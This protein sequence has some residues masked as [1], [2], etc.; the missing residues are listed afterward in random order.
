MAQKVWTWPQPQRH[1]DHSSVR[2]QNQYDFITELKIPIQ[3]KWLVQWKNVVST[4][5]W[6][7]KNADLRQKKFLDFAS[8][9]GQNGQNMNFTSGPKTNIAPNFFQNIFALAYR[10]SYGWQYI[11]TL[12]GCF[13]LYLRK[14]ISCDFSLV[15]MLIAVW[16][17]AVFYPKQTWWNCLAAP[18]CS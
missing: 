7:Y 18:Q 2:V 8:Y 14:S 4:I 10:I 5:Y 6:P 9:F 11:K 3:P 13:A 12:R 16:I 15:W 1:S 17:F